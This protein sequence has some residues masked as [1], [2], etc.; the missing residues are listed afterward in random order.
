VAQS[1]E[2]DDL[3]EEA[4]AFLDAHYDLDL[5]LGEWWE[6]LARSGFAFPTWPT[7]HFGRGLGNDALGV[8]NELF[9]ERAV[10]GAPGGLG[11]MMGGPVVMKHGN[12]EQQERH[13][14]PLAAGL[15]SWCQFFSEPGSGSDLASAQT[16]AVRDGDEWVVNGQKVWTSGARTADRGM[17]LA[18]VDMDAP[19]H[20][21]LGYFIIPVEQ[22]GIEIRPLKQM[23]G[24]ATFNE[25]F[26]TD[27][28]VPDAELIG[29]PGD[30]WG[31]A[32]TT[33]AYERGGRAGVVGVGIAQR[34][35]ERRR[36]LRHQKLGDL[37]ERRAARTAPVA[38][39]RNPGVTGRLSP[40]SLLKEPGAN[41][42][43]PVRQDVVRYYVQSRVNAMNQQRARA[44]TAAGRGAGPASSITKL[45]RSVAT[46]INR[47]LGPAILGAAGMLAGEG[48]P[49]GGAVAH[50]T[51]QA[52]SSSIAGGTD[53]IQHNILGER[54]LGLPREPQ[55]DRDV[56]FRELKVGT[57]RAE[58][59][60]PGR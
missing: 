5:T 47:D 11:Q 50:A 45:A 29:R 26:F 30:G 10:V 38:D 9:A 19:K 33:L 17:L 22:P 36:D 44:E 23:T 57:V 20:R 16:R 54:V 39:A 4:A 6:V 43:E 40:L 32:V 37:V 21:G 51:L 52:P 15:E 7:E 42:S 18:R 53:E 34:T 41:R 8:L 55:V 2:L 24:D 1:S 25:V 58:G 3:R 56:P 59:A 13:L 49:H 46:R 60:K 14:W 35:G 12:A 27:A 28:R 48:A 31:A